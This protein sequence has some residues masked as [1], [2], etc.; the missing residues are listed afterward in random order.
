[1]SSRPALASEMY[2]ALE[3]DVK[4]RVERKR[5][6]LAEEGLPLPLSSEV[7]H[8]PADPP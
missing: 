3:R 4:Q 8:V 2:D 6:R 5:R 7:I 1:M